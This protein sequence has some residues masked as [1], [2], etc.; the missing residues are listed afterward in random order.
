MSRQ[1]LYETESDL[2]S[3]PSTYMNSLA[4]SESK[5]PTRY[6]LV[7][8]DR[9]YEQYL[10]LLTIYG[11]R[12]IIAMYAQIRAHK[13][14]EDL[15]TFNNLGEGIFIGWQAVHVFWFLLASRY[16]R[17]PNPTPDSNPKP[18]PKP[19]PKRDKTSRLHR[20]RNFSVSCG[21]RLR[22]QTAVRCFHVKNIPKDPFSQIA[23]PT[24]GGSRYKAF[25][26][27]FSKQYVRIPL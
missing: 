25:R 6:L 22:M 5:K 26:W 20:N 14:H 12:S 3:S 17:R 27:S 18:D 2:P 7:Q 10:V 11:P 16:G 4:Y 24:R 1:I 15:R 21:R 19:Q 9:F 23:K 13:L 8:F